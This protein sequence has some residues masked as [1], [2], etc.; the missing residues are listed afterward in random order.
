LIYENQL[1]NIS[2]Y[3]IDTTM[4][5]IIEPVSNSA[6]GRVEKGGAPPSEPNEPAISNSACGRGVEKGVTPSKKR[7]RNTPPEQQR[8]HYLKWRANNLEKSLANS[9]HC[10]QLLKERK[11]QAKL[12]EEPLGTL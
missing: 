6:C 4:D 9:K 8:K 3:Y 12:N 10:Y 5:T 7:V 1:K 2:Y 11:N